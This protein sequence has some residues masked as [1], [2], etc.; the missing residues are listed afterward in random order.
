MDFSS[1]F[2]KQW[3]LDN[4]IAEI[5]FGVL[6][7]GGIGL[8]WR[9]VRDAWKAIRIY[10]IVSTH[11]NP[12]RTRRKGIHALDRFMDIYESK[13]P[14]VSQQT[15]YN[16]GYITGVWHEQYLDTGILELHGLVTV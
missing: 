11:N 9:Y 15:A 16:T 14:L 10:R 8:W 5:I 12:T 2:D 6:L 1:L 3:I 4:L 13:L 7:L